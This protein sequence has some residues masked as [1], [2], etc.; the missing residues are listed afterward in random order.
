[1]DHQVILQLLQATQLAITKRLIMVLVLLGQT[2]LLFRTMEMLHMVMLLA[3]D[4]RKDQW[5]RR[6]RHNFIDLPSIMTS[7]TIAVLMQIL[8]EGGITVHFVE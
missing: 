1:M 4:K 8:V 6:M 7:N 2:M 3:V 5:K